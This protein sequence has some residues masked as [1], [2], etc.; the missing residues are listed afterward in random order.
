MTSNTTAIVTGAASPSGIGRATAK[1]LAAQGVTVIAT[2][3]DGTIAVGGSMVSTR[4]ELKALSKEIKDDGGQTETDFVDVTEIDQIEACV[5]KTVDRFGSINILVNNVGTTVGAGPFLN[6]RKSDWE[7]SFRVNLLGQMAFCQAVIPHMQQAGG[8]SIVN[9]GSTASLGASSGSG[10]YAAMKHGVVAL[11]KSIAAEFGADGIRCNVVCP[12]YIDTE[13][14]RSAN[15]R[16]AAEQ[17]LPLDELKRSRYS[18]VSLRRAGSAAEVA[19]A[20]V[21]LTTDQSSFI[22]GIALPV[23]GGMPFGI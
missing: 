9:V 7:L 18:R 11:T 3:R 13:M 8:G 22:T 5:K 4:D 6:S 1:A 20:I 15:E 14:H 12:G 2:D 19:D 23:A 17:S 10:A 16:L 21:Y